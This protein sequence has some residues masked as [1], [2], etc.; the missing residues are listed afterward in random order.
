VK[1][2]SGFDFLAPLYDSLARLVF[3]KSIVDSQTYY[4]EKIPQGSRVLILGGGTGWLLEELQKRS[5][6]C[7]VWYIEVSKKMIQRASQRDLKSEVH[8]IHGTEESIPTHQKFDVVITNFY[9]D[10][11]SEKTL[12]GVVQRISSHMTTSSCWIV[13][14]FIQ[15]GKWWHKL[16]L[17]MMYLFFKFVCDIEA[18]Q[19][20]EWIVQ[21]RSQ[22]WTQGTE[23]VWYSHFIKSTIWNRT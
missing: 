3:G 20:P 11:F 13:T 14:D 21:L 12:T 23:R 19:L 18:N 1:T 4:L 5:P 17:N 15:G 22:G 16:M 9:L 7:T 8:F 6:S 10:L 2:N